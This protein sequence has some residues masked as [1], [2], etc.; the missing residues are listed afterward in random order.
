MATVGQ[1]VI[2]RGVVEES[3]P[4]G[5]VNNVRVR[6]PDGTD[7]WLSDASLEV[8]Q[9]DVGNAPKRLADASPERVSHADIER[10]F[11]D[12]GQRGELHPE[13]ADHL[14]RRIILGPERAGPAP[15]AMQA[16]DLSGGKPAYAP[17]TAANKSGQPPSELRER[18]KADEARRLRAEAPFS[19][20]GRSARDMGHT[21]LPPTP[22]VA[23]DAHTSNTG[24]A[25]SH[26]QTDD[27]DQ[28]AQ[29]GHPVDEDGDQRP[30]EGRAGGT[31]SAAEGSAEVESGD[32]KPKGG[33]SAGKPGK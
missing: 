30:A 31:D 28:P 2:I 23:A 1:E 24:V 22:G 6:M 16:A 9:T 14:K 20:P 29:M 7:I 33:K 10:L 19:S 13:V 15:K 11:D 5:I 18:E 27:R 26:P 8:M 4:W 17:G 21:D 3:V 25:V 12:L 32:D